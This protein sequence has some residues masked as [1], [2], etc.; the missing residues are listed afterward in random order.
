MTKV[1]LEKEYELWDSCSVRLHYG[2]T[3]DKYRGEWFKMVRRSYRSFMAVH[4]H[5]LDNNNVEAYLCYPEGKDDDGNPLYFNY[6]KEQNPFKYFSAEKLETYYNDY[7]RKNNSDK[8]LF[9]SK[10]TSELY[11]LI[12]KLIDCKRRKTKAFNSYH[13][14]FDG[15][16]MYDTMEEYAIA[17]K[18]NKAADDCWD[19]YTKLSKEVDYLEGQIEVKKEQCAWINIIDFNKVCNNI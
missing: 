14:N 3:M 10:Q 15:F 11:S 1:Y 17:D 19:E 2:E 6:I 5:I 8:R 7:Q 18:M 4:Y 9:L 12:M 13:I 16:V